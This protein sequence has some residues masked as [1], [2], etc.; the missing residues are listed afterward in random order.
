HAD[1]EVEQASR[2]ATGEE[3]REERDDA[4]ECECDPEEEEHDEVRDREKPFD[5]P[6]PATELRGQLAG[7]LKRIG[8][9]IGFHCSPLCRHQTTGTGGASGAGSRWGTRRRL[10]VHLGIHQ[11][12]S[13]SSFISA[14]T[15][16]ARMTVASKM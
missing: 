8:G 10:L 4:D 13:P 15:S 14:G 11:F 7:E 1:I 5:E 2:V 6:E 12:A 3:N 16:R 9:R